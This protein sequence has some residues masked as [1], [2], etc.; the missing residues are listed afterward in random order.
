MKRPFISVT[1]IFF[2][3]LDKLREN[4]RYNFERSEKF[5]LWIVGFSIGGVSII[6][7]N[8]TQFGQTFNHDFVK[9]ILI[10]FSTSIIS[11]IIY[12]WAFFIFQVQYQSIEF[13]LQGAFSNKEMMD[14]DP[15]DMTNETDIKEVLRRLKDD[16]DE[17]AYFILE[18]YNKLPQEGKDFLLNDIKNHYKKVGE[19]V[20]KEYEFSMNYVKSTFKQAFG[21]SEK[22][23]NKLFNRNASKKLKLFGWLTAITFIINCLAFT[24]VIIIMCIKY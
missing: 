7:T 3:N 23:L 5:M 12:R 22:K 10:L 21:L 15:E 2:E 18:D 11:G 1:E 9:V 4:Q 17:D 16:F 6:V 13:Y 19:S 20:K 14:I 8:L 24:S